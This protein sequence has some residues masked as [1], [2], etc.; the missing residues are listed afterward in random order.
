[1]KGIDFQL[2][3][4]AAEFAVLVTNYELTE[5]TVSVILPLIIGHGPDAR[6]IDLSVQISGK[7]LETQRDAPVNLSPAGTITEHE[8]RYL[9][10]FMFKNHV[11]VVSDV[12]PSNTYLEEAALLIRKFVYE[13][14]KHHIVVWPNPYQDALGDAA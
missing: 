4:H 8:E 11:F 14:E 10:G 1:M 2:V 7:L 3:S 13:E 6:L 12:F 9:A 5:D